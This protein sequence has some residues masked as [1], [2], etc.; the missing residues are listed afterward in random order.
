[1]GKILT[2]ALLI[3]IA[4]MTVISYEAFLHPNTERNNMTSPTWNIKPAWLGDGHLEKLINA[5]EKLV[6]HGHVPEFHIEKN[7]GAVSKAL[8]LDSISDCVLLEQGMGK[9]GG[10]WLNIS[11]TSMGT[12]YHD[13]GKY[14]KTEN[15]KI[16][17][18]L[19]T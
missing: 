16:L 18:R 9:D 19:R 12:S 4:S 6:K 15:Q 7:N 10:I 3:L 1:M 8:M 17:G 11:Q 14:L 2:V 13:C 5:Q